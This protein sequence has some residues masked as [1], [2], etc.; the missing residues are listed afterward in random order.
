[1][2]IEFKVW[3]GSESS[4]EKEEQECDNYHFMIC[5]I[6]GHFHVMGPFKTHCLC[7]TP[8]F[9]SPLLSPIGDKA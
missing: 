2:G 4:L 6:C 8:I 9:V 5:L 3:L 7:Y 1:M